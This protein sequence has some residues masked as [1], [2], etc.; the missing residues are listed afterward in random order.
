M[1]IVLTGGGTGGHFYPLIAV[2]QALREISKKEKLIEPSIYFIS[3][4]KYNKKA[5]YE[6]NIEYRK[7]ISGK[8]RR[9]FSL[10]NFIDLFKVAIGTFQAI[11][12]L[13]FIF[14]DVIFSKGGYGSVPVILAGRI[15][16]IPI[17]IHESDSSFGIANKW[18]TKFAEK[19]AVSYPQ[20]ADELP[21]E[22]K[23]KVA[24]TGNPIRQALTYPAKEGAYEFLGL[25]PN[26]P[27]ILVLGGSQ[28]AQRINDTLIDCAPNLLPNY[29][30]I[31]QVGPKHEPEMKALLEVIIE[32]PMLRDRYKI[33]GYLDLLAMRMAAGVADLVISRAGS[34]I[35]EIAAWGVP[36]IIIPIPEETSHDQHNNAFSYARSGAATV[37]EENN[38]SDDLLIEEINSIM[39]NPDK[40]KTMSDAAKS[41]A[42]LDAAELIAKE[43]VRI[44]LRHEA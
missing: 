16:G 11:W 33:F 8:W 21:E 27:V 30:I 19:I 28:G 42:R 22:W 20:V 5:L 25:N 38:L 17:V 44:A 15:L 37:L 18:A 10:N 23:A 35:F 43:I 41:F 6:A 29:Q 39:K 24:W 2:T 31:H 13:F 4:D 12:H 40:L 9:Y 14:P 1:K 3:P 36:S 34:T 26:V 7:V 32:D